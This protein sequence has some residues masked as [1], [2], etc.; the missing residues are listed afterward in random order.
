MAIKSLI[1]LGLGV[2]EIE[3]IYSILSAMQIKTKLCERMIQQYKLQKMEI[4][5]VKN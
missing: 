5:N 3:I 1:T 2:K 4:L